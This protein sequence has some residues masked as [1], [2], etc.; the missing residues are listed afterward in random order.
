M[1][2]RKE[3]LQRLSR[4]CFHVSRRCCSRVRVFRFANMRDRAR[5]RLREMT[6]RYPVRV[7]DYLLCPDGYRLL[8]AARHPGQISRAMHFFN[9]VTARDYLRTKGGEGPVWRGRYNITLIEGGPQAMRC[10]LDMDFAMVRTG[11]IELSHP[12]LWKHSGH[13]ELCEVR[14][15]Y[16]IID[17]K[18]LQRY[19]IDVPWLTFREW[20]IHA[21]DCKWSTGEFAE[22]EWWDEAL[23]VGSK[24]LCELIAD[25]FPES[26]FQ[27]CVYPPLQSIPELV[28]YPARTVIMSRKR[29]R[30]FILSL[31]EK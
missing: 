2:Y 17:R 30:E 18:A 13:R 1:A 14:K 4:C 19:F 15:R 26:H 31:A 21:A 11:K 27:L 5:K 29:K 20:Y 12:L 9:T 28:A 7:L 6:G 24:E 25:R 8:L 16:R 22:E 23:V 10:A 3:V